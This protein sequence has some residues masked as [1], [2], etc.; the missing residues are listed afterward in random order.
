MLHSEPRLSPFSDCFGRV[1]GGVVKGGGKMENENLNSKELKEVP[2]FSTELKKLKKI[3]KN[4]PKDKKE[5]GT[6]AYRKCCFYV[7]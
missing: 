3:F 6:K 5:F 7:R 4:I 2:D 1:R